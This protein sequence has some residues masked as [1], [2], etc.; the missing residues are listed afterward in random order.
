[1]DNLTSLAFSIYS[2]KGI[3]ALL[4]GSGI[5]KS[6]GIPTSWEIILDM[7]KRIADVE[8]EPCEP[9]PEKWY[10]KKFN[11]EPEYSL[12]LDKLTSS[13]LERR[14]FLEPYFTPNDNEFE[15]GL[16]C[17]TLAHK[18][19]AKLVK[20]GYIK[21]IITTNFDRLLE[22][23]LQEENVSPFVIS[24][25]D[26]I[27]GTLPLVHSNATILKIN[28][29][30]MDTRLLNIN[31][32]LSLYPDK[33]KEYLLSVLNDFGIISCGWS[34]VWDTA[35]KE[36]I[37]DCSNFR[38]GSYW[39]YLNPCNEELK[40]LAEKRKGR[41]LQIKNADVFF[42][43]LN[44][45]IEALEKIE[46]AS[47]PLTSVIAVQRLKKYIVKKD[48]N[49]LLNDLIKSEQK[50][51]RKNIHQCYIKNTNVNLSSAKDL[52]DQ[53]IKCNEVTLPLVINGSFWAN[54]NQY[55]LFL[56]VVKRFY[57]SPSD[58]SHTNI[59]EGLFKI[60]SL[61]MI[62]GIGISAVMKNKYDLLSCL[63][64]LKY[65]K[66]TE[67]TSYYIVKKITCDYVLNVDIGRCILEN[68][69]TPVNDYLYEILKTY[70]AEIQPDEKEYE[71]YFDLFEFLYLL[72]YK[73]RHE[74]YKGALIPARF[75]WKQDYSIRDED[76]LIYLFK[77]NAK[78]QEDDFP[79]L[80]LGLFDGKYSN[81]EEVVKIPIPNY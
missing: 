42:N 72:N 73:F 9:S 13:S 37:N 57:E 48:S 33:M 4:L 52:I 20:R 23:A 44:E 67:S 59:A 74:W 14:N 22:K 58:T 3:Y 36:V 55:H 71:N 81:Y 70:F 7:I 66:T 62:Y 76:N 28:G 8:G 35:L 46:S 32:E 61:L 79:P 6:S 75:R 64:D 78:I 60:N 51:A 17:P 26:N 68:S 39:T 56:D 15:E 5:S 47:H 1:M 77:K 54:K 65:Q 30:Y 63:F 11:E 16:K 31:D 41:T 29:D 49:I 45:K 40:N 69:D 12:L 34:A 2:N 53:Y 18:A 80:K 21:V 19:I 24:S 43:E 25:E 10:K 38:F 50:H 27:N